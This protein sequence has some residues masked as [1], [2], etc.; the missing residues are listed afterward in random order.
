MD[1]QL[2]SIKDAEYTDI[3]GFTRPMRPSLAPL[4][5]ALQS[6]AV[7]VD[8]KE[9]KRVA[10]KRISEGKEATEI[11]SWV[12]QKI[13]KG[14]KI[15]FTKTISTLRCPRKYPIIVD[16]SRQKE[17]GLLMLSSLSKELR[18]A[19]DPG[20]NRTLLDFD[21]KTANLSIL[22][23]V[24]KDDA[25]TEWLKGDAHQSTGDMLLSRQGLSNR[26]RRKIGKIINNS[27]VAGAGVYWL[28]RKLADYGIYL[29]MK[30]AREQHNAW[31]DRFPDAKTFRLHH[32]ELIAEKVVN[33]ESHVL[34]W[35]GQQMFY[36]DAELLSGQR[37]EKGWPESS[38]KRQE[39]AE[40]SAFTAL[41]RAYE[42]MIL[43]HVLI[44]A[45]KFGADLVCPMFDGAL[46]AV[47][48]QDA[49]VPE[50]MM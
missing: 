27:I 46:F 39:K 49:A 15:S 34:N 3:L 45:K 21:M 44:E 41:L 18:S 8:I 32:K 19:F 1:T 6:L 16:E 26:Q 22:A 24:S 48:C 4:S 11:Q 17:D 30:Q 14:E 29:T 12:E 2:Q 23:A 50:A 13:K 33:G 47:S 20:S 43:N 37:G 38:K 25:M 42:S 31:W 40:R 7:D 36:F 9:W 35:Y 10:K 28:K 5:F